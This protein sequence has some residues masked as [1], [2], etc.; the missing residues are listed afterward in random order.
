MTAEIAE[1]DVE[2]LTRSCESL[3]IK[4]LF[5][6][7]LKPRAYV[8]MGTARENEATPFT[9]FYFSIYSDAETPNRR[10]WIVE[11]ARYYDNMAAAHEDFRERPP[12]KLDK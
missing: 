4:P 8:V 5:W 2:F 6:R 9:V 1:T 3:A 10:G 12:Y 11:A 7:Q